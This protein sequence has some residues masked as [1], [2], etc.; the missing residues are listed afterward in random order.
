MSYLF[1][2]M[3]KPFNPILVRVFYYILKR[4]KHSKVELMD[5][6]STL[7]KFHTIHLLVPFNYMEEIL[8]I[9]TKNLNI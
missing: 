6:L 4:E 8:R 1:V 2:S 5:V 9:I 3:D 7:N